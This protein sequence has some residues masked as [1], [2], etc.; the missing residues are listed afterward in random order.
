MGL[1]RLRDLDV[2]ARVAVSLFLAMIGIAYVFS[3]L[4]VTIWVGL[5]TGDV[6]K[7]YSKQPMVMEMELPETSHATEQ[8]I[9]IAK[10]KPEVHVIDTNL[11]VQDTHVHIPMYAV[12]ALAL[13]GIL[14]GTGWKP[15]WRNAWIAL[16]FAGGTVDFAGQWLVKAGLPWLA[17]LTPLG[18]WTMAATYLVVAFRATR[19]MWFSRSEVN[20]A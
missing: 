8:P 12:I 6:V 5:G 14:L 1:Y 4:M 20:H 13:S 18:G 9:D 16:A 2:S 15:F 19:E 7:A 17:F 10:M 3:I 11:L